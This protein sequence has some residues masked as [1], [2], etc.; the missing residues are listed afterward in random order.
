MWMAC[1]SFIR[2]NEDG[3]STWSAILASA[4][5]LQRAFFGPHWNDVI[6]G[7]ASLRDRLAPVLHDIAPHVTCD[8][9]IRYW[10]THD[11]H[12]NEALLAEVALVRSGGISVHLATVQDHERAGYLWNDLDFRSRF[13]GMHYAAD[14]GCSK[15]APGFY[16]GIEARTGFRP[17]DLFFIDDKIAN[18]EA[19]I[20]SGWAASLWTGNDTLQSLIPGRS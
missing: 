17:D 2:M 20:A 19:A 11:T 8:A 16:K 18:V 12:I 5:D 15:P 10:F 4:S 13:D 6:L 3:A 1:L 9:L 14:L 7:R